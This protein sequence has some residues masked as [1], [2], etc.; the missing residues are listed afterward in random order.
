M[1]RF[2][3]QSFL[4]AESQATLKST[5]VGVVGLG[6][7]GSHIVQQFAHIGIGGFVLSDPD[8][9]DLTNTTRLVGGTLRDVKSKKRKTRIAERLIRSLQ[10][11]AGVIQIRDKWHTETDQ[12]KCCDLIVGAVDSFAGRDE[13]ERFARRHLI[14]YIDIGMDVHN[15]EDH[16]SLISGQ[17]ILSTPGNP[18]LRCCG[19][20]T[21]ERLELEAQKYGSAGDRPQVVWSNGV[22]ASTAVGLAIQTLSPWFTDPPNFAYFEYDG[23]KGT[24]S[25]SARGEMLKNLAC[26]HHPAD[27]VGDP[28]F[29]I[30]EFRSMRQTKNI[31]SWWGNIFRRLAGG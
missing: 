19:L 26:K 23:N 17:V 13:L 10:P 3:R 25:A 11:A 20:V 2:V 22:L 14:P 18:C 15:I 12:L 30:R 8:R 4:G 9:I 1:N 21:A 5:T 29:D 28:F 6:G 16:G 31:Y 24:I 7:G 27:E